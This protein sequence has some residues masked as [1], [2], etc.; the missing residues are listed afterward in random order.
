METVHAIQ[1]SKR[2]G[3][4]KKKV[5]DDPMN[6]RSPDKPHPSTRRAPKTDHL[7]LACQIADDVVYYRTE[8]VKALAE[9]FPFDKAMQY[10]DRM[11]PNAKGGK[12]YIDAP[13]NKEAQI[14]C[15]QKAEVLKKAKI[16]YC[17]A[18]PGEFLSDV[19]K[20]SGDVLDHIHS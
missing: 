8:W 15:D 19:V 17:Y 9:A 11:Y 13:Q 2:K 10:C 4:R 6:D 20:R 7:S 3:G 16:R 12:L 18:L 1:P 14:E 5:F